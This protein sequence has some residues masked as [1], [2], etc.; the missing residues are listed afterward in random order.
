L[1]LYRK[2]TAFYGGAREQLTSES[3][4]EKD[5]MIVANRLGQR[6]ADSFSSQSGQAAICI[7]LESQQCSGCMGTASL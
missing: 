1:A 5:A 3:G 4:L 6:M 2:R 7:A